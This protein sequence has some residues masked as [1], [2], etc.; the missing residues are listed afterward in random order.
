M[1][2]KTDHTLLALV[3][4]IMEWATNAHSCQT[5]VQALAQDPAY[6]Q[7]AT[8]E[9]V[10]KVNLKQGPNGFVLLVSFTK[11]EALKDWLL[12]R[13]VPVLEEQE[14]RDLCKTYG[15]QPQ[16]PAPEQSPGFT[17]RIG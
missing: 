13:T 8:A 6:L 17:F 15:V 7:E 4:N 16:Q 12:A 11:E 2:H 1:V 5:W 14:Y 3:F 10:L 9:G